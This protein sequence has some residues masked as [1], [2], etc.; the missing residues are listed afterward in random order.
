MPSEVTPIPVIDFQPFLQGSQVEKEA[1]AQHLRRACQQVGF[2]Y[3]SQPGLP[4][5]LLGR[6]FEQS[7]Q[8]FALP[9]Q[10]K[11]KIAWTTSESNRGY[12][13]T[14]RERL[15]PERPGDFKET[16]NIGREQ[17]GADAARL[18]N[19]W[20][21]A[22]PELRTTALDFFESCVMLSNAVLEAMAIALQLP[23]DFF[24]R[25]HDQQ[26]FT[27]RLLHYPPVCTPLAPGQV[28]AGEHSDYGTITLLFQDEVGGL[29][30]QG[31]S[32]ES[33]IWLPAPPQP[34]TVL[35]NLGD[36]MERW[37]NHVFRSTRHR[38]LPPTGDRAHRSRYSIAFFCDANPDVE[39]ACLDSCQDADNPPKYPPIRAGE[40]L[41]SRLNATY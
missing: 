10:E 26:P 31:Q 39:V 36:L 33:R 40:Y 29:E 37:T 25:R 15:N 35:I 19:R 2:F 27:L 34:G 38:V 11:E 20:P 30:V 22:L 32:A 41:L 13:C 14:G 23:P 24:I 28:R 18:T 1:I 16:L 9:S 8:F 3:L 6:M 5:T 17:T 12:G 7:H 21:S 4:A